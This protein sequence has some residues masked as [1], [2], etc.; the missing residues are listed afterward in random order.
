ML[1]AVA[2]LAVGAAAFVVLRPDRP[3][4]VAGARP[5]P[6]TAAVVRT[7]LA[8]ST[9]AEGR[10]GFDGSVPVPAAPGSGTATWL[11]TPGAVV[12]LGERVYAVD[13]RPVPLLHG[14]TP[15]WRELAEG[16]ADG[17]DVRLLRANLRALGVAPNLNVDS[18]HFSSAVGDA[19]ARWQERLGVEET[20]K[21]RPGDVVVAPSDLR[22]VEVRATL[23]GA[24]PAVVATA[25][26]TARVVAVDLAVAQQGLAVV[27]AAVRVLLPTGAATPGRVASIGTVATSAPRAPAAGDDQVA[28]TLPVRITLDDPAAAGTLD[29]APVSVEFTSDT[30]RD[31]LAVPLVALLAMPNGD[32]AVDVVETRAD[33][34]WTSRRVVVRLGFFATGQVEVE[35]PGLTAGTKVQVPAR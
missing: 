15:L 30:H 3:A 22:V 18:D 33:G 6:P 24:L 25:S 8:Q 13:N 17:P 19:V 9:R 7:D 2:V 27:G 14:D 29:G 23:G 31:V 35:A 1:A 26:S 11:P 32:Y 4:A 34:S 16:V 10:L 20:R 5:V 12:R 28:A 21:I